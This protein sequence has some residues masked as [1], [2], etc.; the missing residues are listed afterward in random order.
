MVNVPELVEAAR[1]NPRIVRGFKCHGE[2]GGFSHWGL[3]VLSKAAEA[4][5]ETG[6]PL[7]MHTGELFPVNDAARP[8]AASVIPT[9]LSKLKGGDIM[10][11]IYSCMPDGIMGAGNRV[12][13]V[14]FAAREKGVLFDLGHGI[15]FSFRIARQMMEAGILADTIGSDVHGDF[16]SFHDYSILDYSLLGGLNKLLALGMPMQHAIGALTAT[17]ARILRDDS[18]GRLAPG[19]RANITVLEKLDGPWT[20][21]DAEG[22]NLTV[23]S[24]L[25]PQLVFVDGEEIVPDCGLLADVLDAAER[26]RGMTRRPVQGRARARV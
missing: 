4:G 21:R 12:P 22:E 11:H 17:P 10:A 14:V 16:C 26:P 23:Q 3:E 19:C 1:A 6:L 13:D 20:Y 8:E 25:V 2:S 15:N 5:Q 24:R 9:A 7:Y 18:I